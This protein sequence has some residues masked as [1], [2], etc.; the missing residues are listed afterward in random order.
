MHEIK[1]PVFKI[2]KKFWMIFL[3]VRPGGGRCIVGLNTGTVIAG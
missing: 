3:S 2:A 1:L